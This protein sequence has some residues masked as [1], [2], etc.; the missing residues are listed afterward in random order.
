MKHTYILKLIQTSFLLFAFFNNSLSN[1]IK[2]QIIKKIELINEI[3]QI[4]NNKELEPLIARTK[5]TLSELNIINDADMH[6]EGTLTLLNMIEDTLINKKFSPI[7]TV[8]AN[9]NVQNTLVEICIDLYLQQLTF[10]KSTVNDMLKSTKNIDTL[11]KNHRIEIENS[12]HCVL[13]TTQQKAKETLNET[14][15][16][17]TSFLDKISKKSEEIENFIDIKITKIEKITI[18]LIH[19]IPKIIL[20]IYCAKVLFNEYKSLEEKT[21][22]NIPISLKSK[23]TSLSITIAALFCITYSFLSL[24]QAK[25]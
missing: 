2:E 22:Q 9:L 7:T 12:L 17:A 20:G 21:S 19:T 13:N 11:L 24:Q 23:I 25:I 10:K 4:N 8:I 14:E 18:T 5:K 16:K 15:Q 3:N 1:T 6:T